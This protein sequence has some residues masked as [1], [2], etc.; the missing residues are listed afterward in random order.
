MPILHSWR[1]WVRQCLSSHSNPTLKAWILELPAA[2]AVLSSGPLCFSRQLMLE[3]QTQEWKGSAIRMPVLLPQPYAELEIGSQENVRTRCWRE[4]M[5]LAW[6]HQTKLNLLGR[7][8]SP[9]FNQWWE[10]TTS[11]YQFVELSVLVFRGFISEVCHLKCPFHYSGDYQQ[12][13]L[14]WELKLRG[15]YMR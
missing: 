14:L 13:I 9:L 5:G 3:S 1:Q 4:G 2:G 8:F 12:L 6:A 11:R 15:R 10:R 7:V